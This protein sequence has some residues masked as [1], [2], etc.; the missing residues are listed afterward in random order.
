MIT[1]MGVSP[2]SI[3]LCYGLAENVLGVTSIVGYV[4][5]TTYE[6]QVACG[7]LPKQPLND[8]RIVRWMA[9]RCMEFGCCM[10]WIW[11]CATYVDH[12]KTW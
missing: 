4:A 3:G 8:V 12:A 10:Y 1:T 5:S 11:H 2:E 9:G 6:E 7:Y